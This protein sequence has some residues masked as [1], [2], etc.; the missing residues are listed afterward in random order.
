MTGGF[1]VATLDGGSVRLTSTQLKDLEARIAGDV[2]CAGDGGWEEAVRIWNGMVESVP[3]LVVQPASAA[4]VATLVDF[5][6]EHA[7][8]L[9]V[10]GGGHNIAGTAVADGGMMVD[11][12]RLRAIAVDP[13]ARLVRVG[14]GCR[15]GDVDRAT[16]EHGLATVLGFIS[17]TGVGGLTLGGGLGYLTRRFGWTVDNL[18]EVEIVTADGRIRR[19]SR[20]ENADLFWALRGGGGNLGVVTRFTFRLHEV[21]PM[22]YGGLIA[23]PFARAE[24]ILAAYRSLTAE[25]PRDL[26]V[27]LVLLHAPPAPFVPEEW[28]GRKIC[29]M[30][31]CYTGDLAR[32]AQ[33]VQPIRALGNPIVDLLRE[34][35]YVEVQSYLDDTEPAGMHYYWKTEYAAELGDELLASLRER[36][37]ACTIPG[38]DLGILHL[39]GALGERAWDDGAVGNRDV[40]YVIG[41]KGMWEPGEPDGEGCQAWIR[42]AWQA[43]RPFTLGRTYINF[44]TGD[45]GE[46]R[47]RAAYGA[48]YERLVAAKARFDPGNLFRSNR[49]IRP[50]AQT[51]G[52]PA[53]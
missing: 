45:E 24:E 8:R 50:A 3:A 13:D 20:D 15:L 18:E 28:R 6:R 37:A 49:N 33:V 32:A 26:S 1:A 4:D 53:G 34:Q 44:Q 41:I 29:G 9:S 38:A 52:V 48:N 5:A 16:Q 14:A 25:A 12:A 21:G 30:A 47:V 7:L 22:V 10:K 31:V 46:D 35:P 27:W 23:W 2:L 39:D 43:I 19:A 42:D 11:L 51:V 40:R 36:F 17:R